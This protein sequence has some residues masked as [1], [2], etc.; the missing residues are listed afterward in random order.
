[1]QNG[2]IRV[3][4]IGAGANARARHLPGLQAI[5]GVGVV[6]V[7]NRTMDSAS[8]VAREFGIP[9]IYANWR[10]LIEAPD[11]DAIVIS[12]WPY[13]HAPLT[14]A[15]L[16]AGK[17]VLC[18][19]RMAMNLTEALAMRAAAR[20]HAELTAQLVPSPMTLGVDR[21]ICRLLADGYLGA[22]LAVEVR[23]AAGFLDATAPLHWREE[24][25]YSGHN[26]M[27]LGIWYEALMRWLGGAT[28]VSAQARTFVPMRTDAEGVRR[29]IR[30]PDHLDVTAA[31]ACGAQLHMLISNVMGLAGPPSVTLYGSDGTLRFSEDQLSGGRRGDS[32]L[33]PIPIPPEEAGGWR[34]EADF[35]DAI[36]GVAPVTCTT[37]DAGV[38]YM[39][40]TDAVNRGLQVGRTV[41]VDW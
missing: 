34:V 7:C 16:Q 19:A 41:A 23:A 31:M 36:R 3:G 14:I 9:T 21:T 27:S 29:A 28:R 40:F 20:A 38:A 6:S 12:T 25:T 26:I 4:I 17:H 24:Y 11:T 37:F 15:A 35:I 18:E 33:S 13:L 2:Y 22:P 10:Q 32:A 39:A 1:M 8:R 30:I 5:A